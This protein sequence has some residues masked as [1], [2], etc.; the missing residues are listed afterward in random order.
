MGLRVVNP[1]EMIKNFYLLLEEPKSG[2]M[3]FMFYDKDLNFVDSLIAF[4]FSFDEPVSPEDIGE[5][6]LDDFESTFSP[7][8]ADILAEDP[9]IESVSAVVVHPNIE[10]A[11]S[12]LP[13]VLDASVFSNIELESF[14]ASDLKQWKDIFYELEGD[15]DPTVTT[16][17]EL[18]QLLGEEE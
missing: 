9:S 7:N 12:I 18:Y 8:F 5:K 6:M 1:S 2:F 13:A 15:Y 4:E 10:I 11:E 3:G 14:I 16:V 17:Y